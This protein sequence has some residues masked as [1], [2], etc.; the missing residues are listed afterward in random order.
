[1]VATSYM[2][3]CK[4]IFTFKLILKIQFLTLAGH[5]IKR[6][7]AMFGGGYFIKR[8]KI[9]EHFHHCRKFFRRASCRNTSPL[10]L[11]SCWTMCFRGRDMSSGIKCPPAFTDRAGK[12]DYVKLWKHLAHCYHRR[13]A[14]PVAAIIST[15]LLFQVTPE[16][17]LFVFSSIHKY[18]KEKP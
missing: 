13:G 14:H 10:H 8:C 16:P 7:V 1:M 18:L 5:L 2:R 3:L 11:Q 15:L 17:L 9:T 6:S 12:G 4:G